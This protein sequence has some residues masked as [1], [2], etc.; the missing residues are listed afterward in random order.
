M[1]ISV[2][3]DTTTQF[4]FKASLNIT[5]PT[6]ICERKAINKCVCLSVC[7]LLPGR[8]VIDLALRALVFVLFYILHADLSAVGLY[9][10]LAEEMLTFCSKTDEEH[11]LRFHTGF[12][13]DT[14]H[15]VHVRG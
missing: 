10:L 7:L 1:L 8:E 14:C 4:V 2:W 5:Q 11:D 12:C 3:R 9:I 15:G 13:P 6:C